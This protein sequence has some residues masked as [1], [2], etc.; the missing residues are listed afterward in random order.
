MFETAAPDSVAH[1]DRLATSDLGRSYKQRMLGALAVRAGHRVLDLGCGPGT[2]LETLA[3][4]VTP[5]SAVI[6]LG[7]PVAGDQYGGTSPSLGAACSRTVDVP[8]VMPFT[9]A[10]PVVEG[11]CRSR[12]RG[13][14]AVRKGPEGGA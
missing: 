4:A 7:E 8:L 2:D 9:G 14:G 13:G 3:E 12:R 10:Y 5:T 6:V 1:L 11:G